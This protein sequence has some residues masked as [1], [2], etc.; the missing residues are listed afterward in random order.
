MGGAPGM[1]LDLDDFEE[2][3]TQEYSCGSYDSMDSFIAPEV[4]DDAMASM[5][6]GADAESD[7]SGRS[8]EG[9]G[10]LLFRW[11]FTKNGV[12]GTAA[13]VE[14]M[15][16]TCKTYCK[17][18]V[19]QLERGEESGLLHFQGRISLKTKARLKR[20]IKIFPG[21]HISPESNNAATGAGEFYACKE[22]TRVDGPWS[23]KDVVHYRHPK[24]DIAGRYFPWQ[25][26][27]MKRLLSQDERKILIVVDPIGHSGKTV[28]AHHIVL[29]HS[30]VFVPSFFQTGQDVLQYVHN[31]VR[32]GGRHTLVVDIPR[33]A[34]LPKLARKLFAAFETLKSGFVFDMRYSGRY[35]Y[36]QPPQIVCFCNSEPDKSLLTGDRWDVLRLPW[37]A[38][39]A[40]AS[41]ESEAEGA[42]ADDESSDSGYHESDGDAD[43]GSLPEDT[44][45]DYFGSGADDDYFVGD[46]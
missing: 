10:R 32:E 12:E 20:V 39:P 5:D 26:E 29:F 27:A 42:S 2:L 7:G 40:G 37:Q 18:F 24:F 3:D 19:W 23:D 11:H 31:F 44:K 15:R 30:G 14:D 21:C 13:E 6:E 22:E 34:L 36:F 45:G 35:K 4:D 8:T 46:Q 43:I 33:A 28:L 16:E 41:G 17:K 1:D 9:R 25:S 38:D